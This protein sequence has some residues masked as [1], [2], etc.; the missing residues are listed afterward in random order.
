ML[1]VFDFIDET[2]KWFGDENTR[3]E[4]FNAINDFIINVGWEKLG[5]SI[6]TGFS[7]ALEAFGEWISDF[8]N[9][10]KTLDNVIE[11]VFKFVKGVFKG[12]GKKIGEWFKTHTF[13]DLIKLWF[14]VSRTVARTQNPILGFLLDK[15][16]GKIDHS[17]SG[18]RPPKEQRYATGCF[19]TTGQ[20]FIARESGAEMVGNIGGRTA[21][22]N[23]DQIVE[24]VSLGVYNAVMDAMSNSRGGNQDIAINIDGREV[25][26]AVRNENNNFRRRTGVSAF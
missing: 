15:A 20:M 13:A 25:F 4:I 12:V 16:F 26:R 10:S 17:T 18:M 24:A 23:N 5:E 2:V 8:E 7:N 21:V 11:A 19:P 22:A 1:G 6:G 14:N 3:K 9:I